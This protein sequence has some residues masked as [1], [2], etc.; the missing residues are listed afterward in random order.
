MNANEKNTLK[1]LIKR[2]QN[3]DKDVLA[4]IMLL[5]YK[6]LYFL[7]YDYLRDK[8]LAQDAVS[9]TFVRLLE[10]VHAIKNDQ[11]LNGYLRTLVINIALDML[12]K[13]KKEVFIED[14]EPNLTADGINDE[15][16]NV[17]FALSRLK[18]DERETLLL[19]HYGYT[20][21][22]TSRM[23]GKTVNQVRLLLEKAKENFSAEYHKN[24]IAETL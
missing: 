12:R 6:D 13:R 1:T 17:R 14:A 21:R 11:S 15:Q 8:M 9:E 2:F 4:D 20:L 3:G 22:E 5:V 23:T 18:K 24:G 7:A 19:W 16:I 10:K